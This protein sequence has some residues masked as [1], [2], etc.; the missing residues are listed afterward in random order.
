MSPDHIPS[1]NRTTPKTY[2]LLLLGLFCISGVFYNAAWPQ[3]P[4]LEPDSASYMQVAADLPDIKLDHLHGRTIGYPILL[5]LTASNETPERALFI[6]QLFLYFAAVTLLVFL[7]LR[8]SI[9]RTAVTIL[10]ILAL[11]PY[12]IVHTAYMLTETLTTFLI[13]LGLIS[14]I[15][16]IDRRQRLFL[17]TACIAL[18]LSALAKPTYQLLPFFFAL[19]LFILSRYL[20]HIKARLS[21]GALGLIIGSVIIIGGM[22]LHN[23]RNTG[24]AGLT[25]DFGFYLSTKTP[26]VL[27]RLP[28]EY[29]DVREILIKY[30]DERLLSVEY[31]HTGYM[32]FWAA[33]PEVQKTT[34]LSYKELASYMLKLNLLLIRKAP[35]TY[36][37]E[38]TYSF[39]NIWLPATTHLSDFHNR[40]IQ[41]IWTAMHYLTAALFFIC[42]LVYAAIFMIFAALP[43]RTRD[44]L[45][46]NLRETDRLLLV[47]ILLS[48]AVIGYTIGIS[49][50]SDMCVARH[51]VPVDLL[52][53]S[54]ILAGFCVWY[55]LRLM[56]HHKSTVIDQMINEPH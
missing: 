55:R 5:I 40:T 44:K 31:S 21:A 53:F 32:Y 24:Y 17:V 19:L 42:C 27:E 37:Q 12:N 9:P 36:L 11:L 39:S 52:I 16:W 7:L 3:A 33:V 1:K 8:L 23:Y 54:L 15:L 13:I 35:L 49:I 14:L 30:R 48:L 38:V 28:D 43:R 45:L 4:V 51:R 25:P 29:A 6:V 18:P 56:V 2:W 50:L 22:M 26:R 46:E 10:V 41:F 34:G 47:Y 20:P